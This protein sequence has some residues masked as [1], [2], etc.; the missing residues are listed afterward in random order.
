MPET[1]HAASARAGSFFRG[2]IG[3]T[4]VVVALAAA[5]PSLALI[6]YLGY[7]Q[8]RQRIEEF[9]RETMNVAEGV[10]ALQRQFAD[11]TEQLLLTLDL[12]LKDVPPEDTPANERVLRE[13]LAANISYI[14]FAVADREGF[15][16]AGAK[17]LPGRVN[18]AQ[19]L[20]WQKAASS[21]SFSAGEFTFSHTTKEPAFQFALPRRDRSGQFSG[22][23]IATV[24]LTFPEHSLENFRLPKGSAVLVTDGKGVRLHRYPRSPLYPEGA[25][26]SS[27]VNE[28]VTSGEDSGFFRAK[29]PDGEPRVY[30]FKRLSVRGEAPYGT[31]L[32]TLPT[33]VF[34]AQ[35]EA[36]LARNMGFLAVAAA[37]AL[38]LARVLGKSALGA[39]AAALVR[40]ARKIEGGDLTARAAREVT[41]GELGELAATFDS[42]AQSLDGRDKGRRLA[43]EAL[44]G[45]EK[46]FRTLFEHTRELF[47][48]LSP[49]G[50]LI[51]VN[52]AALSAVGARRENVIGKPFEDTPWWNDDPKKQ[53]QLRQ[54]LDEARKGTLA[55]F[56]ATHLRE[57]GHLLHVECSLQAVTGDDG[58][59]ALFI[60][61]GR[62]ITERHIMESRLRHMALHDALTGLANRAL[63]R[64][65][66][67]QAIAWSRRRPEEGYALLFI[68]LDRFK[69]INDS[70]GHSVGDAILI[71]IAERF[72]TALRDGDT[73]ARYGGDEFVALIRGLP[74]A[75]KAIKLARR[76]AALLSEP[77]LTEGARVSVSASVGIELNPP[78]NATPDE[79]IRNA[80]LAMHH[81]KRSR[82]RRPKVYT[83]RLLEDVTAIRFMEQE[84]PLA[85]E[86]GQ[87]HLAFQPIVDAS[88]QDELAGFEALSRWMHPERGLVQPVEFI[89]MAE[90]TGMIHALGEWV[91]RRAC[92]T[93]AGWRAALPDAHGVFVSVNV[94]PCQV[95][96][97][98]FAAKV[99]EILAATGLPPA[100]LHLEITETAIM[101]SSPQTVER[102]NELAGLGVK[103]SIDDFG[104]GYSN[105]ALMTRLPVADLKIDLSIVMAMDQT[106][107]YLAVVKSIV[108]MAEALEL[109]V[110]AEGVETARQRDQLLAL[111]CG[112]QQGY[113]H[114][115]PL[116]AEAA[117]ELLKRR[118]RLAG[119]QGERDGGM[120][121]VA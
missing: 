100:M 48:L 28:R 29:A 44:R 93:M 39:P 16:T 64:D 72:R 115:R 35:A 11:K 12:L 71:S 84:L 90:E 45:S 20:Y 65:R 67:G 49:D 87:F 27:E 86:G 118:A 101:D 9:K 57:D 89:R 30:T 26:I 46:K 69:V 74:S 114:A 112:L 85:L 23:L 42:M 2:H 120:S 117:Y 38:L 53:L 75:R 43:E 119:G 66:I 104:S 40:A 51:D 33:R 116:T 17:P 6:F 97:V 7:E 108:T 70:L 34:E 21:M 98:L 47:G 18:V 81:A 113:L 79:L 13:F 91:L 110:V 3:R 68:D 99:R 32:I 31:L 59:P 60:A 105:L 80:N 50:V 56:D 61:E 96:D 102:L 82:K 52:P 19:R 111:G 106:P 25:N 22:M 58:Q 109:R 103:L 63:L 37:A 94:S 1:V 121:R 73:L 76:L 41:T 14:T 5:A 107:K 54:A 24:R 92:Q 15:L 83:K 36:A 55:R 8:D 10:F 62:D 95:E 88:R 78:A 77:I 4:L